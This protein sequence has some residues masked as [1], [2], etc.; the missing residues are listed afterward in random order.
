MWGWFWNSVYN[1]QIKGR[2]R[3]KAIY[4]LYSA[5]IIGWLMIFLML[6]LFL[7]GNLSSAFWVGIPTLGVFS[8][9]IYFGP[10]A[11][12]EKLEG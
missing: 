4:L 12:V 5:I 11:E 8:T 1:I 2:F 9:T 3:M 7:S 10:K 6:T